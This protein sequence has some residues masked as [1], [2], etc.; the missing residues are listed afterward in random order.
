MFPTYHYYVHIF[1]KSH[2]VAEM[3]AQC[4]CK[5]QYL[6][7]FTMA[8]CGFSAFLYRPTLAT[9]Q[10]LKSYKVR[11]FSQHHSNLGAILHRFRDIAGFCAPDPS[12]IP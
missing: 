12:P 5:F 11:L 3:T 2:A 1:Y 7:N 9:V 10:M 8:S 6:S 4:R